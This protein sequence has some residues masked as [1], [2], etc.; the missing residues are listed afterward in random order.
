MLAANASNDAAFAATTDDY[1]LGAMNDHILTLNAGSSSLKFATFAIKLGEP[2]LVCKGYVEGIGT[3][4]RFFASSAN[5]EVLA[6]DRW[7]DTADGPGHVS[8]FRYVWDWVERSVNQ[9]RILAV[10]HRVTHGGPKFASP[11]V[12]DDA[13]IRELQNLVPLAPLHQP[14]NL[15]AIEAVVHRHPELA[16]VASFDTAFHRD[17]LPVSDRFALPHD[18][19]DQGIRRYGFHGLS[20]ESI[21]RSLR[22]IAPAQAA[23]RVVVAHLG[24]GCSLCAMQDGQSLDTTMGFSALDGLPMGTRCGALDPGVL[25]YLLREQGLS[26]GELEE[27]LY[28]RSGLLGLSGISNDMRVL[29]GSDAPRATEAIDYFVY[30]IGKHLGALCSVL[31]GLDALVFTGG[32]GEND[33]VVR[34]RVCEDA[35]WLGLRLDEDANSRGNLRISPPGDAPAVWVVPTDEELMIAQHTLDVVTGREGT[36]KPPSV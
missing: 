26:P 25:I 8:A 4:P 23:G 34:R 10:G 36:E 11:V 31:G 27:L 12:I 1:R 30:Q 35:A 22:A 15:A 3:A 19:Y 33:S 28:T 14:H 6:E 20:Y 21:A 5:G 2:D 17:R 24:N 29:H 13:V 32:I 9:E 7:Q 18:Y 16:Q